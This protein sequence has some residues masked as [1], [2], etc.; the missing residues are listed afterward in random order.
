MGL[1]WKSVTSV[2][3]NEACEVYLNSGGSK[4]KVRGLVIWYKERPLPAKAVLRIAYCLA[5]NM[6]L[7]KELKF[8][9][10]EGSLRFLESLGF[11]T[12]RLQAVR[13]VEED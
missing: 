2:H 8:S 3:V 4:P 9:S 10:S 1:N 6:P 13:P 11:H 12:E 5:N 7:E